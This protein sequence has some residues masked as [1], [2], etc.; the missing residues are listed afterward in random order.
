MQRESESH[1]RAQQNL[2]GQG[3]RCY[4]VNILLQRDGK[5]SV[6]CSPA[7]A[8]P[9]RAV[10]IEQG[11]GWRGRKLVPR[12]RYV[13]KNQRLPGIAVQYYSRKK[14]VPDIPPPATVTF[15]PIPL[16]E[17][18][19]SLEYLAASGEKQEHAVARKRARA[20]KRIMVRYGIPF[21]LLIQL[22]GNVLPQ[23][24]ARGMSGWWDW[25]AVGTLDLVLMAVVAYNWYRQNHLEWILV[26]GGVVVR[27]SRLLASGSSLDVLTPS[28][29]ILLIRPAQAGWNA[30]IHPHDA[31]RPFT[32]ALTDLERSA[33]LATWQSSVPTP[34]PEKLRELIE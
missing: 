7:L 1:V 20:V 8:E 2:E 12:L 10:I 29:S 11:L 31:N 32:T 4:V 3:P 34:E 17:T 19:P 15:E 9:V 26:P 30:Q 21:I 28:N 14:A 24:I 25:L 22:F 27:K 23:A 16:D 33:L 18:H 5:D 6:G 13:L